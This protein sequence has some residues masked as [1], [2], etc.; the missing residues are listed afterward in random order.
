[1]S[2]RADHLFR[3]AREQPN[4]PAIIFEGHGRYSGRAI[5]FREWRDEACSLADGLVRQGLKPGDK[6]AL[7][8]A[9]R[10][11]F[12]FF[13]YACFIAGG[14]VLPLN[15]LYQTDEIEHAVNR[16]EADFVVTEAANLDRVGAGFKER[17]PTVRRLF[18]LEGIGLEGDPFLTAADRLLGDA[19]AYPV[20]VD[21]PP[22]ALG[23]ML[24]TSATTG[25]AKGVMLTLGN[26]DA[27]YD[28][29]PEWLGYT[30]ADT[31]LCALPL[32]NTFALN[33]CINAT[34]RVGATLV[35]LP[36]FE[37]VQCMAAIAERRCTVFPCVPTMLQKIL[38]HPE[39]ERF[40]LTSLNRIMVGAA[41]V[42][43]PLLLQARA[44]FG[45]RLVVITGY[46][47]TEGTALV[48]TMVVEVDAE[49]RQ[50]MERSIGKP[51]PGMQMAIMDESGG[52]VPAGSIGEICIRGPNV[53]AGYY[54]QPEETAIALDRGWLHTGDVGV[55]NYEGFAWIVD[56]KKDI[57]IRGGQNIYPADIEEVLYSHEAVAEAAVVA[58][59]DDVL[60]EVP[61]AYVALKPGR[62]VDAGE[63]IT[64]CKAKLAYFKV[65]AAIEILPE[66]PK[67]PTGKILRRGLRTTV[68]DGNAPP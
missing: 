23:E 64:I 28:A 30:G 11:E 57:I 19:D 12:L 14:V 63:L 44:R 27:N 36:R 41:P 45:D 51:V 10:P 6:V 3:Q 50:I 33:Q 46:G 43:T 26:L 49:G 59:P 65:P 5:S 61:K 22:Q 31:I 34:T 37:P 48:T 47:L 25:R 53:M 66:L 8:M 55:M 7:F 4:K 35:V 20:P 52:I 18:V 54:K 13:E 60:G 38:S 29:T 16:C 32:F 17:C 56:R 62:T 39:I 21:L 42:P 67:G 40:D 15:V 1:V 24:Y 9:S 2:N 58:E 68:L